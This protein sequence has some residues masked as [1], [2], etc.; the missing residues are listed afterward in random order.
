MC[1]LTRPP[2][3]APYSPY[4]AAWIAQYAKSATP[5]LPAPAVRPRPLPMYV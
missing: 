2:T 1:V 3:M 5:A 4:M